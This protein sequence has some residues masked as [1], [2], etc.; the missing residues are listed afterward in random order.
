MADQKLDN[1]LNLALDATERER[2]KSGNL[3]VGYERENGTWE[4]VIKYSGEL[5]A[6]TGEKFPAVPL[7]GGYAVVTLPEDQ[8][9]SFAAQPR[10]EYMEM[11]K[12]LYFQVNQG[13]D[14]SCIREVQEGTVGNRGE[15]E[16]ATVGMPGEVFENTAE[17]TDGVVGGNVR[18]GS[19]FGSPAGRVVDGNMFGSPVGM[20]GSVVRE[21]VGNGELF[22]SP[23]GMTGSI[24][25][26]N[27]GNGEIFGSPARMTGSV[28]REN[29]G[30]G[31]MFGS[32]AGTTGEDVRNGEIFGSTAGLVKSAGDGRAVDETAG[33]S[34]AGV[35]IG[36]VDS[37]VDWRHPDF[38]DSAGKSRILRLWD[39]SALPENGRK[40]PEGYQ[41][42]VEYTG[43][44]ISRAL[45]LPEA[46]G[47]ALIPERDVSGHG[48]SVLGIAAGNGRASNG[49]Y[50]G[51]AYNSDLLV[52]K[53]GQPRE[54][55]FPR[56][57]ELMQGID[58][59]VRQALSMNR[60]IAIN[61]SFGNNYGSH[62]GDSL[63]E[64]Y[65]SGAA[66]I[67]R[68]VICVGSGN[69]GNDSIHTSV[70]VAQNK[71]VR[72]EF[73]V[74]P[75]EPTL[76]LQ[77]WKS[78]ADELEIT[79]TA[80]SGEQ[81]GPLSEKIGTQRHILGATELLIYYGKPGPFQVTQE[82]YLDF[83]PVQT[84]IDSG[85]WQINLRGRRVKDGTC[86]LWLPGGKILNPSTGFYAPKAEETLT[87]PSTAARVITVAAYDSRLN[88]YADFSG[89]GGGSLTYPK[90]DLAAPGVAITAPILGNY[91]STTTG[92]P[93][94]DSLST[95]PITGNYASVTGTSFATP[96]VTGAAAL[97]MEWGIIRGNDPFLYGEK[98]KAY[99][100]RGAQPLPGFTEYPNPQVGY[101]TL[102]VQKSIPW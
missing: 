54:N 22:G 63:L 14:A 97:L 77:L 82:I 84:Y 29:V 59:L 42:G 93:R 38:C 12:R 68:T 99:L 26:E 16:D 25:R 100:R 51:V 40:P 85:V 36:I 32:T 7:F 19:V 65:M 101:G 13:I 64:T 94:S 92:I 83:L 75:Y 71:N 90:P 66:G 73:A 98:V 48:T 49:V 41:Q 31:E 33:L 58:Y 88:A 55:S 79:L 1:L 47:N 50:R 18:K 37:G 60:P 2:A 9:K 78:Y 46:E 81:I 62:K 35:L 56:T 23:A 74:S 95:L 57:T 43:E 61:V 20:T 80:P 45:A 86:Q 5:E 52:V 3:N 72:V 4:V 70:D 30:N 89:R 44:E 34:G 96:F 76:N 39:Q 67:G 28:V 69:N 24:V 53:L 6:L 21:N 91:S 15:A 102:C 10:V 11:P 27:V 17:E 8:I 87:I